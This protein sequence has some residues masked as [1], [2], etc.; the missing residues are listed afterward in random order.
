[1]AAFCSLESM[2][3]RTTSPSA[4]DVVIALVRPADQPFAQLLRD[5]GSE[6]GRL[7]LPLEINPQRTLGQRLQLGGLEL[8]ERGHP[9]QHEVAARHRA[10]RVP[11]GVVRAGA[12]QHADERGS[13]EHV[14]L[15]GGFVEIGARRHFDAEGVEEKRHGVQVR[16]RG[17][18]AWSK[19]PRS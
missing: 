3:V 12:L 19:A 18:R 1:L 17:S 9:G 4:M 7:H 14:Q 13:L 16:S 15:L 10:L 2:P 5:M 11:H 6:P 8:A